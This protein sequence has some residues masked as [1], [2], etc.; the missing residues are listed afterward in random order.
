MTSGEYILMSAR[1]AITGGGDPM[2]Y[3]EAMKSMQEEEWVAAM[4]EGM[5]ALMKN[6]AW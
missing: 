5:D 3:W 4:K 6:D 1:T 2:S